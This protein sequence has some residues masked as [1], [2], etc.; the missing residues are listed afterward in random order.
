MNGSVSG[1]TSSVAASPTLSF[2][3]QRL[4]M[5]SYVLEGYEIPREALLGLLADL[6]P[7]SL[8][9]FFGDFANTDDATLASKLAA[10]PPTA[11]ATTVN[12][13]ALH[14]L[15]RG[16]PNPPGPARSASG[17]GAAS[18]SSSALQVVGRRGGSTSAGGRPPTLSGSEDDE[19][20]EEDVEIPGAV[21]GMLTSSLRPGP[22][23]PPKVEAVLL[24][25]P[26][27]GS[28]VG[29]AAKL[30]SRG[31]LSGAALGRVVEAAEDHARGAK[32]KDKT[33]AEVWLSQNLV[34]DIARAR[35][36]LK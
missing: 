2:K 16:S 21:P 8:V 7:E 20:E 12:P 32:V 3:N 33:A 25:A 19:E 29:A 6:Y 4:S 5:P 31:L 18:S 26:E 14:S 11:A 27:A 15:S 28:F 10:P 22:A 36:I 23:L 1:R 35:S 13:G 34:K 9:L 17:P 30:Y 24:G